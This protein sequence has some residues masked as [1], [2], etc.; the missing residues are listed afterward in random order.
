MSAAK[1]GRKARLRRSRN[2][3]KAEWA[4]WDIQG[5][6]EYIKRRKEH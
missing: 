2:M 1:R 4:N 6:R 5:K 3:T